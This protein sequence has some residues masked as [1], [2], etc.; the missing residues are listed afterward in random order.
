MWSVSLLLN[1]NK[2]FRQLHSFQEEAD[3]F[4]QY[5][6]LL[7]GAKVH[8]YC[9]IRGFAKSNKQIYEL[10]EREHSSHRFK[11]WLVPRHQNNIERCLMEDLLMTFKRC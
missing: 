3:H 7:G 6:I 9:P 4:S 10:E 2:A 5:Q 11:A 8:V 1:I